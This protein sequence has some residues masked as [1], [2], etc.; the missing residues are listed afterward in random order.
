MELFWDFIQFTLLCVMY[1]QIGQLVIE[2]FSFLSNSAYDGGIGQR[3][4][5]EGHGG[6]TYCALASLAL[7]GRQD[8]LSKPQKLKVLRWCVFRLH[9]GFQVNQIF[10]YKNSKNITWQGYHLGTLSDVD[11]CFLYQ[12]WSGSG[13]SFFLGGGVTFCFIPNSTTRCHFL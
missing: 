3:P 2:L 6:H 8:A 13:L 10:I 1:I 11:F 9:Q 5:V 4:G 7:M 12:S